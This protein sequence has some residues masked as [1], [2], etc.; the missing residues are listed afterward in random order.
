MSISAIFKAPSGVFSEGLKTMALPQIS[1]GKVFQAM[2][3]DQVADGPSQINGCVQTAALQHSQTGFYIPDIQSLNQSLVKSF[4]QGRC[5]VIAER[6][7]D[8]FAM[9]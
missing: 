5:I 3:S 6:G 1:A 9:Q 7:P 4:G 2:L 8:Y